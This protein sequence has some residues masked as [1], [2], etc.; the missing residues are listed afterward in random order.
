MAQER[1]SAAVA[2]PSAHLTGSTAAPALVNISTRDYSGLVVTGL[3]FQRALTSASM[4]FVPCAGAS[5]LCLCIVRN[6]IRGWHAYDTWC[7]CA[8]DIPAF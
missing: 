7:D 3:V 8:L 6:L 2:R 4:L 1:G 5:D